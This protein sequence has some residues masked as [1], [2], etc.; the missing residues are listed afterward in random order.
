MTIFSKLSPVG[1]LLANGS[2]NNF[3]L[4][5]RDGHARRFIIKHG[6]STTWRILDQIHFYS[7]IG[8]LFWG[9]VIAYINFKH[10]HCV[11]TDIPEGYEPRFWEYEDKPVLQFLCKYL[12]TSPMKEHDK[13]CAT[14]A[15]EIKKREWSFQEERAHHLMFERGDYRAWY[16]IPYKAKW[17]EYSAWH[18][19]KWRTNH[20]WE[21]ENPTSAN[22]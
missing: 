13:F 7:A 1:N 12:Y 2:R 15:E 20:R 9:S 3:V 11:L 16:Y 18:T 19:E 10:G 6:K 21:R 4:S 14:Y 22:Q 17:M 8:F 5:K